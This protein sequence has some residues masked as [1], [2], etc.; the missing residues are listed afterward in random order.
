MLSSVLSIFIDSEKFMS[1][2]I[3]ATGNQK[4]QILQEECVILPMVIK[5]IAS[6]MAGYR[7]EYFE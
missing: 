1:P 5:T 3:F 7:K 4:K 2:E 6:Y